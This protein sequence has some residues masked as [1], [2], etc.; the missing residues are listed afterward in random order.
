MSGLIQQQLSP[1]SAGAERMTDCTIKL[2][3][4]LGAAQNG[5]V[6]ITWS[7]SSPYN[8]DKGYNV[9][10]LGVKESSIAVKDLN[11]AGRTYFLTP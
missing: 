6:R 8:F 1:V 4:Q 3:W 9:L 2:S 11:P 7:S 5:D 10:A